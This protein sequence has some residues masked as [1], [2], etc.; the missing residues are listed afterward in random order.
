M[1]PSHRNSTA[2]RDLAICV[3]F[4]A[5]PRKNLTKYHLGL[6]KFIFVFPPYINN[7]VGMIFYFFQVTK[8]N[9]RLKHRKQRIE[10]KHMWCQHLPLVDLWN[11]GNWPLHHATK[12]PRLVYLHAFGRCCLGANEINMDQACGK[13]TGLEKMVFSSQ[14]PL[15]FLT[16]IGHAN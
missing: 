12:P 15:D 2:T 16:M 13:N 6:L 11:L 7:H 3:R 5:N 4:V 14:N 1:P 10:A 8:A 9:P